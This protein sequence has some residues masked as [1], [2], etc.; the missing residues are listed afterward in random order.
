M[1]AIMPTES[2]NTCKVLGKLLG[3]SQILVVAILII[4]ALWHRLKLLFYKGYG[5]RAKLRKQGS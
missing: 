5:I 3:T 1:M 2:V 4:I